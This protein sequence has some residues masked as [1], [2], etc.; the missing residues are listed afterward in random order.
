MNTYHI[1]SLDLSGFDSTQVELIKSKSID[2]GCNGIEE[3]NIDEARV[4]EILG[5]RS[6]SGGDVPES[7]IQEVE[8]VLLSESKKFKFYFASSEV[9]DFVL[10]G[11]KVLFEISDELFTI[12]TEEIKDWNEEW[13]KHF[14]KIEVGE[15][16]NIVPAWEKKELNP[17]NLYIYPGMGFGTGSH[18]TTFLCLKLML[19]CD[20]SA[21]KSCLDFGCGSGI[22]GLSL[23][24]KNPNSVL[25]LLDIDQEA[26]E[27]SKTNIVLNEL[28]LSKIRLMLDTDK[29]KLLESYDLIFANILKNVLEIEYETLLNVSKSGTNIIISGLLN[30]QVDD[31]VAYYK[32]YTEIKRVSKGDWSAILMRKS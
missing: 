14:K 12:T 31:V 1:M 17:N 9:L 3:F 21:V 23:L 20:L 11:L 13:R 8:D 25:D 24:Q 32:D 19:E 18:E 10:K 27:N 6:Y 15:K 28:D 26:L 7:V 5:E 30:P 16:L 2:L 4:D 29:K 22:L